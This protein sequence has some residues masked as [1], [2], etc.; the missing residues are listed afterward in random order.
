MH[1]VTVEKIV[2][3]RELAELLGISFWTIWK[4]TKEGKIPSI[5]VNKRI[6]YRVSSVNECLTKL[7]ADSIAK[8]EEKTVQ[9]GVLRRI[10]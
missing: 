10:E 5:R 9:Y 4:W 3:S 7:E 6:F 2:T 1:E 8:P